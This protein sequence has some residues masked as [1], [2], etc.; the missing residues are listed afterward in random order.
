M[1]S[2]VIFVI[3][4]PRFLCIHVEFGSFAHGSQFYL[5][6]THEHDIFSKLAEL[7][8]FPKCYFEYKAQSI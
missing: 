7:S 2:K 3:L 8:E 1:V 5:V 4:I 6:I